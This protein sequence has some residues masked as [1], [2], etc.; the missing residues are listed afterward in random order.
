M[1]A[2]KKNDAAVVETTG[3]NDRVDFYETMMDLLPHG[4]G[5]LDADHNIV[6]ANKVFWKNYL[7]VGDELPR[8]VHIKTM[9]AAFLKKSNFAGNVDA[10]IQKRVGLITSASIG[11]KLTFPNGTTMNIDRIRHHDGSIVTIGSDITNL[12]AEE[13]NVRDD[14][15]AYQNRVS[16]ELELAGDQIDGASATLSHSCEGIAKGAEGAIE[17]SA[18]VST[19]TEEMSAS[20]NEIAGRTS[21]AAEKCSGAS[22]VA[23]EAEAKVAELSEAVERIETF[24]ATIQA[25]AD[26]TNLLALNATIEAARAGEAGRGFAV[27]ASEVKSLSQQT[28]NATAEISSQIEDVRNV[29]SVASQAI[30]KI[31]VSIRDISEMSTDTASAVSQQRGVVGEIV[32]HMGELQN[33][34]TANQAAIGEIEGVANNVRQNSTQLTGKITQLVQEGVKLKA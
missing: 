12:I 10:E 16:K 34:V 1:F 19:A 18:A 2:K 15:S 6:F 32:T 7:N 27:V 14:F 17:L 9:L 28:A 24:A 23:S 26:Q 5:F 33:V 31:T 3:Q 29:S 30:E 22:A 8:P 4:I 20:I 21:V 13:Q 25:I 11:Q